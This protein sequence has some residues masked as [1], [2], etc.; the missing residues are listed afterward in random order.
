MHGRYHLNTNN[1]IID[2]VHP[3]ACD[4]KMRSHF[5]EG[6]TDNVQNAPKRGCKPRIRFRTPSQARPNRFCVVIIFS[7]K[8]LNSSR[9]QLA[10]AG[11]FFLNCFK[12]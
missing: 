11:I 1:Q 9:P 10:L 3:L 8:I 12:C 7:K 6:G 4:K 2:M 5:Q